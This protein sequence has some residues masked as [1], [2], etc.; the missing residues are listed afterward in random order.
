MS[1]LQVVEKTIQENLIIPFLSREVF[2]N[3]VNSAIYAIA[4]AFIA[5]YIVRRVIRSMNIEIDNKFAISLIPFG[6]F[7]SSSR[8]L[9]DVV[10]TGTENA[11]YYLL[12]SPVIFFSIFAIAI[13]A[14]FFSRNLAK[15][16]K[17]DGI[18]ILGGI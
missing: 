17:I 6:L 8:V 2:Y 10:F 3:P 1:L 5:F 15:Y 7:A 12:D 4:F 16:A 14:L 9:R 18:A 13:I 11:W